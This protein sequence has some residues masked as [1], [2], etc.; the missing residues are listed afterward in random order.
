MKAGFIIRLSA[1]NL[2]SHP[3]RLLIALIFLAASLTLFCVAIA[4]SEFDYGYAREKCL[5][6]YESV[7]AVQRSEGEVF[8]AE[9]Q[10]ALQA[11]GGSCALAENDYRFARSSV[12]PSASLFINPD[13][14][15]VP[16]GGIVE[17]SAA[18]AVSADEEFISSIGWSLVGRMPQSENEIAITECLYNLIEQYGYYDNITYPL[19]YNEEWNPVYDERGLQYFSS[20][21]ELVSASIKLYLNGAKDGRETEVTVVG[22]VSYNGECL[23]SYSTVEEDSF[24]GLYDCVF[25]DGEYLSSLRGGVS[26]L[27]FAKKATLEENSGLVSAVTK[28]DCCSFN[29]NILT[30]V[31]NSNETLAQMKTVFLWIAVGLIA[32]SAALTYWVISFSIEKRRGDIGIL[33]ANGAKKSDIALMFFVEGVLTALAQS[34]LAFAASAFVISAVNVT[35]AEHLSLPISFVSL[36]P[37]SVISVVLISIALNFFATAIPVM[38]TAN[39]LPIECIREYDE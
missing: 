23:S 1:K 6:E 9:E 15:N 12:L 38:R 27:F 39:K 26:N 19:E 32:F 24:T 4:A 21:E 34:A 13:P 36:S 18:Y 33:R 14:Q 10:S 3:W 11:V 31:E 7:Y 16:E 5:Y 30:H 37:V 8:S 22:V 2:K 17:H 25:V 28:A 29:S 20:A 35:L